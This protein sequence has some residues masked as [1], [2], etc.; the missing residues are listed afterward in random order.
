LPVVSQNFLDDRKELL[1]PFLKIQETRNQDFPSRRM[2][3]S[4]AAI[5]FISTI[6]YLPST[7]FGFAVVPNPDIALWSQHHFISSAA[8]SLPHVPDLFALYQNALHTLPLQTQMLTGGVLAVAGDLSAQTLDKSR[9]FD[10]KRTVSFA[11]FDACYRA[12]QHVLYPPMKEFFHGQFLLPAIAAISHSSIEQTIDHHAQ[13]FAAAAEQSLVSQLVVI[14][15]I[16][17]PIFFAVTGMVQ[18]LS[19]NQSMNR[20]MQQFVPLMKRNLLFWI[21]V[22][23]GVFGWV[24]DDAM[25]ISILIACGFIWTM[26]LSAYAGSVSQEVT[27]TV[28]AQLQDIMA[29]D[30]GEFDALPLRPSRT[31]PSASFDTMAY[32][33]FSLSNSTAFTDQQLS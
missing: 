14:P 2:K 1:H 23:F 16:Y 7:V 28:D 32:A 4:A 25:Q 6:T 26:I 3:L 20:G 8:S 27:S 15:L 31:N 17:Y 21:P 5:V 33:S 9:E 24:T 29:T 22:Q 19:W 13:V 18:G 10:P 30:E 11:A 12:V